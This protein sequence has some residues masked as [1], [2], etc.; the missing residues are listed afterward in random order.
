M[1]DKNKRLRIENNQEGK[2]RGRGNREGESGIGGSGIKKGINNRKGSGL[3]YYNNPHQLIDKL[4][5]LTGSRK[6]GNTNPEIFN[7]IIEISN[8][9][10]KKGL[11]LKEDYSKFINKNFK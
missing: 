11:I 9:L 1:E 10:L 5:L 2:G 8:E 6:A 7:E 3:M 4:K